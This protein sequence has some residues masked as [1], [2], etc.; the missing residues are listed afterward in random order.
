MFIATGLIAWFVVAIALSWGILIA[1]INPDR[2]PPLTAVQFETVY[3][4]T[5]SM[6]LVASIPPLVLCIMWA[7]TAGVLLSRR[8]VCPKCGTTRELGPKIR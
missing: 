6:L 4:D 3:G 5:H 8:R 1:D 7:V 2:M